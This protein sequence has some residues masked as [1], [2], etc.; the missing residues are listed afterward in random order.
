MN[1]VTPLFW[2]GGLAAA[3]PILLHLIKRESAQKIE[4]PT[5]MF[6][7]K[8]SKRTIRYQ[9]LRH[10]LLLLVRVLALLLLALAFMRPYWNR[11]Q[12]A[13]AAGRVAVAHV[14]LL[15]NSMSMAYEDRWQRARK[16]AAEIIGK[17]LPGDKI[18]LIQFSDQTRVMT[19][20]ATDFAA[21]RSV[22]DTETGLSDR[23]TRYGQA[24]KI[25]EKA[26]LDSATGKHVLYLISDFQKSGWAT[27]E[28]D[29]RLG[30]GMELQCIDVGSEQFSNLALGDVQVFEGDE[31]KGGGLRIRFAAMNFGNDD[32]GSTRLTMSVDNHVMGEKMVDL[33]KG[34]VQG[35]EFLLPGLTAG[36]HNVALEIAD[37]RLARDNRF[38]MTLQARTK[39]QV[40]SVENPG[41]GRTGRPPSFFLVNAL[42]L[43][44]VSPFRLSAITPQQ[45]TTTASLTGGLV[46]W[47]NTP[48]P[49]AALQ[50]KL[51]DYVK[52]GGGLV[53]VLAD[54]SLAADFGRS[55][56]AW[57]PV[58]VELPAGATPRRAG[59]RSL[60]D[61]ALLTDVRLDHPVFRPF[62]E[63]HSGSFSTA[64]FHDH[65]RL[66]P[67]AGAQ[68]LARFDNGDPALIAADV[69]K[70]RVLV[71]ASSADDATND[72][73]VKGVY[74]P[75]WHQILR[76]LQSYRQERQWINVGDTIAPKELLVQAAVHEGK[77]NIDLNQSI[78][79]MDPARRRIAQESATNSI[80]TDL[81]GFYEVR[82]QGLQASVAVNSAIRESDL[83]HGNAEE[84]AAGWISKEAGALQALSPDERPTPEEQDK[85]ARFWRWVL[86][87][88]LTLL[89]LEGLLANRLVLKA[90]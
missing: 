1:F 89:V 66:V 18:S 60:D 12:A 3:V 54:N 49:G 86:L 63:P 25:A 6:L 40:L 68:V 41:A 30:A 62:S 43:S 31:D 52:A 35:Q 24:L 46:I 90:D 38:S 73:A 39:T 23:T 57:L 83:T 37:T 88:V 59:A 17:A 4:F 11:P 29:F 55:F 16:A 10:L 51:Q 47:N 58:K 65:A 77:G 21:V 42:N 45:F 71:F 56:G 75:F 5:L 87:A 70:G 82:T 53:I 79:V 48:A 33:L 20:P 69:E 22:L 14:I 44:A 50:K 61:Y 85:R 28:H 72:L 84:M 13:A 80:A 7:R 32:R 64:K 36:I 76:Y 81:A 78:V 19:L 67:A 15:D 8:I 34:A 9:K 26:A 74:A 2:I 27:D